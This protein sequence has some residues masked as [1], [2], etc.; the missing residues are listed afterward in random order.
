[1]KTTLPL[2][3]LAGLALTASATAAVIIT[4]TS[5]TSTTTIGGSRTIDYTIDGSDLTAAGDPG[6]IVDDTHA[7]NDDSA[8]YWLSG[9]D[10]VSGS[11][12]LTFDLG[13]TFDVT[14]IHHWR[15]TRAGGAPTRSLKTFDIYVS[16]NGG[17]SYSL[18]VAAATL[19]DFALPPYTALPAVTKTFATQSG[20]THIEL[21]NLVNHGDASF[22]GLSEIRFGGE[23]V[24][25]PTTTA[26]LGLGGLALILR[27]RK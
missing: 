5:A 8:G 18:G 26:L 19:G 13:G 25:E 2:A 12:V 22:Y 7:V 17:S 15:Y 9:A 3:A 20:V 24:P 11:E 21:R 27:R 4:P 23:V 1:M 6:T 10:A 16:T 14:D